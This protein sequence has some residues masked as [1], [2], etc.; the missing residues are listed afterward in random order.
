MNTETGQSNWTLYAA[1]N[2]GCGA[3]AGQQCLTWLTG[4][5]RAIAHHGRPLTT[6][7]KAKRGIEASEESA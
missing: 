7:E 5:P 2:T 4:M 3:P 1:C 6:E